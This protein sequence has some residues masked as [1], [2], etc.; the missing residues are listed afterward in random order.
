MKP[1]YAI[2]YLSRRL[3]NVQWFWLMLLFVQKIK[4]TFDPYFF[5]ITDNCYI[6][7][8]YT[9]S[10]ALTVSMFSRLSVGNCI[11]P[12]VWNDSFTLPCIKLCSCAWRLKFVMLFKV[13]AFDIFFIFFW[14]KR[15][16]NTLIWYKYLI[17]YCQIVMAS[18]HDI[19]WFQWC[20]V[21]RASN[22]P[23][24]GSF[25]VK[26]FILS[27]LRDVDDLAAWIRRLSDLNVV[28]WKWQLYKT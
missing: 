26:I 18:L 16:T 24:R 22:F 10:I 5:T 14:A 23:S 25:F 6:F 8:L 4:F 17:Y 28:I 7:M 21:G 9:L 12:S 13:C 15:N 27:Y 11:P 19:L 1:V 3:F 20:S 2:M